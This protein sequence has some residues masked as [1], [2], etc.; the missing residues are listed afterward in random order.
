MVFDCILYCGSTPLG[1]AIGG[2]HAH[3]CVFLII[4]CHTIVNTLLIL[5]I[6][7]TVISDNCYRHLCMK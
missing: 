7:T 4:K 1:L 3:V 2:H 6:S 5:P